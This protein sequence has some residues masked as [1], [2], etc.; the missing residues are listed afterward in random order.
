MSV[1]ACLDCGAQMQYVSGRLR[2]PW[3]TADDEKDGIRKGVTIL[4]CRRPFQRTTAGER[5]YEG[6]DRS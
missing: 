1:P 3:V 5:L 6:M 2:C 4:C